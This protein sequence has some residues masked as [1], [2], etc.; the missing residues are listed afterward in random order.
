MV[1]LSH[2]WDVVSGCGVGARQR[3]IQSLQGLTPHHQL[4][5]CIQPPSQPTFVEEP[6]IDCL[7]AVIPIHTV[8]DTSICPPRS[9][10]L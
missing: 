4:A 8:E 10:I 1:Y 3:D 5:N 2:P 9:G 7:P 6:P